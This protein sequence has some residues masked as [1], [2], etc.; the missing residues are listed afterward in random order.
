MQDGRAGRARRT[1][2]DPGARVPLRAVRARLGAEEQGRQGQASDLPQVQVALLAPASDEIRLGEGHEEGTAAVAHASAPQRPQEALSPLVPGLG[3]DRIAGLLAAFLEGRNPRT[4]E[5]YRQDLQT[6]RA[7]VGARDLV[8]AAGVLLGRS[9]G[10]ANA[11]ALG[12]R[13]HLVEGKLSPATINRRLAALRSLVRLARTLGLVSWTLEVSDLRRQPYRDTRGPSRATFLRLLE[14]L[15]ERQGPKAIRDLALVRLLHDLALR[16]EEVVSLD[17]E[18]LDL[19]G[20]TVAV[21]GK[22]H[23]DRV[24]L[25]LPD[26][27]KQAIVA[28][29]KV[30]G[31]EPGP[32]F[33][34]CDR[35]RKG[36]RLTGRSVHRLLRDLGDEIGIVV[37]PHGLRHAAITEALD[38]TGGDVRAVQKFS[39]HRDVRVLTIYDDTRQDLAGRVARLVAGGTA[40]GLAT[41]SESESAA[42]STSM[43]TP[44]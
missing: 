6:F 5:A 44:S 41:Q 21:L 31:T 11:L 17:V 8:H 30:R 9:H 40:N 2:V 24:K 33:P 18:H 15:G 14:K 10:E 38:A 35:A 13:A 28:W 29:L 19:D 25:T 1:P 7:F 37:R 4:L 12:Y 43:P 23:A 39:R 36:G 3:R 26:P 27:T 16:R 20:G 34:N 42:P 22:G 32:L